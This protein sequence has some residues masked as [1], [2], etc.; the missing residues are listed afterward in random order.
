MVKTVNCNFFILWIHSCLISTRI[1]PS[2]YRTT[3][4]CLSWIPHQ[5]AYLLHWPSSLCSLGGGLLRRL[6]SLGM[7]L[8]IRSQPG[9]L[10][11]EAEVVEGLQQEPRQFR[12][13]RC[14]S[15]RLASLLPLPVLCLCWRTVLFQADQVW[16]CQNMKHT[17]VLSF[18]KGLKR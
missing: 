12:S 11:E 15:P 18:R 16:K 10:Q 5:L 2:L 1:I 17:Q 4:I 6:C 13:W 9:V 14:W 7:E 8:L 3:Q